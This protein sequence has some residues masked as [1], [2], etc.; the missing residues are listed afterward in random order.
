L[1]KNIKSCMATGDQPEWHRDEIRHDFDLKTAPEH[2]RYQVCFATYKA[3]GTG[4]NLNAARHMIILDDEWNPGMED[5]AIGRIDRLN[6]TDQA[7]VHIFRVEDS[8]DDFM[9]GLLEEKRKIT[10]GFNEQ[11]GMDDFLKFFKK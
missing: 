3:F 5:Q 4:I 2:P 8:V 9:A 10:S 1:K 7:N 6:S 11:I